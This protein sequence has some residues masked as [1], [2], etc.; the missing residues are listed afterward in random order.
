LGCRRALSRLGLVMEEELLWQG[1]F[2][3]ESGVRAAREYLESRKTLP[4]AVFCLNDAMAIGFL[5]ELQ[6][7]GLSAPKN[8]A[9]AGYDNVEAAGHLSL[10]SV[11]CPMRLMGQMAARWAVDL[12]TRNER[13]TAHRLQVR[14][15]VRNSSAGK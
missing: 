12:I 8:V 2:T 9:L 11:A 4:D 10:T 1:A 13:P 14:L 3:M 5:S 6:R 7:N 15:V